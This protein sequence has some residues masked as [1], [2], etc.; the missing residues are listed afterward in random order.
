MKETLLTAAVCADSFCS[1]TPGVGKDKPTPTP[2]PAALTRDCPATEPCAP[3]FC[4]AS[5]GGWTGFDSTGEGACGPPSSKTNMDG[6]GAHSGIHNCSCRTADGPW[7]VQTRGGTQDAGSCKNHICLD[8]KYVECNFD[9]STIITGNWID[10]GKQLNVTGADPD[11]CPKAPALPVPKP[12][13]L[14]QN[15]SAPSCQGGC[16][17]NATQA[18]GTVVCMKETDMGQSV[19]ADS[20]CL[21]DGGT[22]PDPL[23]RQCVATAPCLPGPSCFASGGGWTG[24]DSSG[25]SGCGLG[26]KTNMDGGGSHSGIHKCECKT[27]GGAWVEQTR[28]A[29]QDANDCKNHICLDQS[30]VACKFDRECSSSSSLIGFLE[31]DQLG[32]VQC[33]S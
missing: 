5:G 14:W 17:Q 18:N 16:G 1:T 12:W 31:P 24:F 32:G 20:F 15:G 10:G 4:M 23:T 8:A 2:K 26:G 6:G 28:G 25:P 3:V 33:G 13:Y 30:Y 9:N 22:K 7:E 19:V 27:A 21:G 11:V 29:T